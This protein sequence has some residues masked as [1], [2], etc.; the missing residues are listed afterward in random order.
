MWVK[1]TRELRIVE[2][3]LNASL[4]RMK[5]DLPA[6]VGQ[7]IAWMREAGFAEVACV[8]RNLIFA[9]LSGTK[10]FDPSRARTGSVTP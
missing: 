10:L 1:R 2:R 4:E 5:Q 7:Q 6:T 9:V 3:D 8:Y